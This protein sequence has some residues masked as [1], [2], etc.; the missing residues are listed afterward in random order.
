VADLVSLDAERA[1]RAADFYEPLNLRRHYVQITVDGIET[2]NNRHA[3]VVIGVPANDAPERLYFDTE[4]DLLIRKVTVLPT[5]VG[6][7][8]FQVDF[9]DYRD[10]GNGVKVPFLVHMHPSNARIELAPT[11][12]L[13]VTSVE[14]N[15]TIDDSKF[16][17]PAATEAQ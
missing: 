9:E 1:R 10:A 5:P 7:S 17:K 15:V 8:P 4:T 12:T 2:V 6:D 11:A 14:E 13:R 16:A 3:Y